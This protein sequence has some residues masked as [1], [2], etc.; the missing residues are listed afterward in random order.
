M[1]DNSL[2][3]DADGS[4]WQ[5]VRDALDN[6]RPTRSDA[7]MGYR[8]AAIARAV[9][10]KQK[11][12][13]QIDAELASGWASAAGRHV[14]LSLLVIELDLMSDYLACYGKDALDDAIAAVTAVLVR[15]LPRASDSCLQLGQSSF[16]VVLPD[17]PVLMARATAAKYHEA[18]RELG[19]QHKESHL[20]LVTASM[21]LAVTN[22]RG[23]Y[24]RKFF[25]AA[26]EAVKTAQRKGLSR[27]Q[28]IDLRPAQERKRARRA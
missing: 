2:A 15:G 18:I 13:A 25:E 23:T 22:P 26:A 12:G 16:V 4:F 9:G 6:L 28:T 24:D 14:S 27:I 1:T 20:G 11:L 8:Q 7:S 21:G 17:M 10:L 5:R 3:K 19:L